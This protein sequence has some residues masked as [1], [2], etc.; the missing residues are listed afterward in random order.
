MRA[1]RLSFANGSVR[2]EAPKRLVK[3]SF[4]RQGRFEIIV[5]IHKIGTYVKLFLRDRFVQLRV[6]SN[7]MA[8][9]E[10]P[11]VSPESI[12]SQFPRP[13]AF[14]FKLVLS[15]IPPSTHMPA[16]LK[17]VAPIYIRINEPHTR[18]LRSPLPITFCADF[19]H[20]RNL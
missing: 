7:P 3:R 20:I 1:E 4:G 13:V 10:L 17:L 14:P 16:K 6:S 15:F 11:D 2:N 12:R 19:N 18:P 9:W 8:R 5:N